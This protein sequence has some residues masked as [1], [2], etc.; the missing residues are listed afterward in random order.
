MHTRFCPWLFVTCELQTTGI[1]V[2]PGIFQAKSWNGLPFSTQS[3]RGRVIELLSIFASPVSPALAADSLPLRHL[4]SPSKHNACYKC[5]FALI[6]FISPL[7]RM[8]PGTQYS[9]FNV[10]M[11]IGYHGIWLQEKYVDWIGNM[12][13]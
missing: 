7:P 10:G 5:T 2:Q 13:N 4:G 1:S 11:F 8:E 12:P 9:I 6:V 3:F